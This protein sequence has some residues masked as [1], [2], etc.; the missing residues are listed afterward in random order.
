[1]KKCKPQVALF[2]SLSLSLS[3][4]VSIFL[5]VKKNQVIVIIDGHN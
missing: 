5:C 2:L 1:M 4:C 3:L